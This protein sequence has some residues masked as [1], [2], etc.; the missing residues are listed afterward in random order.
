MVVWSQFWKRNTVVVEWR[1][2]RNPWS[3]LNLER[4]SSCLNWKECWGFRGGSLQG[5]WPSHGLFNGS[6][7]NWESRPHVARISGKGVWLRT[8]VWWGRFSILKLWRWSL[9]GRGGAPV[10]G[11]E[12]WR[13]REEVRR[14]EKTNSR[15]SLS[16]RWPILVCRDGLFHGLW[17]YYLF[18]FPKSQWSLPS[19]SQKLF[20]ALT[21][22]FETHILWK[23]L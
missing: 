10:K 19:F 2:I 9:G 17:L 11:L 23:Y 15:V 4:T 8:A 12:G 3:W 14:K 21:T 18:L 16:C 1:K 7:W 13:R 22:F 20:W 5:P 6:P